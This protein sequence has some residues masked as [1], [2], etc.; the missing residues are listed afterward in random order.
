MILKSLLQLSI[1][2]VFIACIATPSEAEDW[3]AFRI[4][5]ASAPEFVLEA[6]GGIAAFGN[7]LMT[8]FH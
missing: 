3:G 8:N 5:S 7:T 4:I 2:V 6:V 1:A